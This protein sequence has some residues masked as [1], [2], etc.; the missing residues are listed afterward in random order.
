MEKTVTIHT[1]GSCRGNPGWGGFAA[2]IESPGQPS[3]A[4]TGNQRETTN[5]AMELRAVLEAL[6]EAHR[7]SQTEISLAGCEI[8]V[9]SDS[10]YVVRP[11]KE[12]LLKKWVANGWR[13]SGKKPVA[14]RQFWKALLT[15]V[16]II[17]L[18][19]RAD[20][21]WEH[22]PGHAGHPGNE[23]CDRLARGGSDPVVGGRQLVLRDTWQAHDCG[24][25]YTLHHWGEPLAEP[26]PV[27][28]EP[29]LSD[30]DRGY[31]DGYAAALAAMALEQAHGNPGEFV[32]NV[33]NGAAIPM[34]EVMTLFH[35]EGDKCEAYDAGQNWLGS[36]SREDCQR[37]TQ[38][39]RWEHP[40][41]HGAELPAVPF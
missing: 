25:S 35:M 22:V 21:T 16:E 23:E 5:N 12:G 24:Q 9:V 32:T 3:L 38:D 31:A 30:Y 26:E 13:T 2:T 36:I 41:R 11:F 33:N 7:R 19:H 29:A 10:E 17:Q 18:A 15:I 14:N 28:D 39:P 34:K 40:H 4:V 8:R 1:D 27:E 37:V 6:Q 20:I